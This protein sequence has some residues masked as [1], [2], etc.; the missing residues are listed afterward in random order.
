MKQISLRGKS[1]IGGLFEL[2]DFGFFVT[3]FVDTLLV[4]VIQSHSI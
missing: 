2:E 1:V 3:L 4:F